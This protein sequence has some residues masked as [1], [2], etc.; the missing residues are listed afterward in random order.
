ML[1][2]W[3]NVLRSDGYSPAQLLFDR[4]QRT[5]LPLLPFQNH[6]TNFHDAAS[7]KDKSHSISKQ[8][9]DQH[10]VNLSL[11]NPG[12]T[13]LIQDPKTSLWSST[14]TIIS[15]WPDMLSYNV[16]IADRQFLRPRHLLRP[17]SSDY[18]P[19]SPSP[20]QLSPVLPRRSA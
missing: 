6:P 16:M 9:H 10:N 17:I 13:V 15:V 4:S 7:S 19:N 14:G 12:Q 8:F 11:L 5:S 1:Y 18:P 2:E 3:R 20:D